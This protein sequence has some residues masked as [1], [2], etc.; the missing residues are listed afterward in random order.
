[1]TMAKEGVRSPKGD[2]APAEGEPV[3]RGIEILRPDKKNARKMPKDR[4]AKLRFSMHEFGDLSGIVLNRQLGDLVGG[5][6]RM[7]QLKAAGASSW[8]E[9]SPTEGYILHPKT[10]E[11]VHIRIVEWEEEKHRAA[12]LV[13][14]NPHLQGEYDDEAAAAQLRE[15]EDTILFPVLAL[16]ELQADLDKESAEAEKQLA[17]DAA[18]DQSGKLR[19]KFSIVI[20][21]NDEDHQR[22]LLDRFSAEGIDARAL[23]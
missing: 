3:E 7:E 22:Q 2:V 6:Q 11:R 20:E 9:T 8:V 1:M 14:N 17:A 23:F 10:G 19:D 15:L 16:D 13:A 4:R 12:Q 5:H 18:G 21:C